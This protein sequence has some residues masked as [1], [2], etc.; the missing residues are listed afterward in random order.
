MKL[1]P[2]E[3]EALN[4]VDS[5]P[6]PLTIQGIMSTTGKQ[7]YIIGPILVELVRRGILTFKFITITPVFFRAYYS[8]EKPNP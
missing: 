2:E 8:D 7:D 1:T 3:Q 6:L 4:A 5:D